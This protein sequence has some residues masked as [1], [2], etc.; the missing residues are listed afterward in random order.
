MSDVPSSSSGG[1]IQNIMSYGTPSA[2]AEVIIKL[3]Y[4][5]NVEV[6][7]RVYDAIPDKELN[8][9]VGFA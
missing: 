2:K 8:R 4:I 3:I 7:Q 5:G 1:N 6:L 9:I